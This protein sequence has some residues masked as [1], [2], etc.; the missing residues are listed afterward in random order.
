[1]AGDYYSHSNFPQ[2]N[3]RASSALMRAE[4]DKIEVG[5]DKLPNLPGNGAEI[6]TIKADATGLESK[7]PAELHL[8]RDDGDAYTGTHDFTGATVQLS[9]ATGATQLASD[10][11]TKLATTAFV[12][13][14]SF[15]AALPVQTVGDAGKFIQT[16]GTNASWVGVLPSQTGNNGK[17]LQTDGV[18]VSWQTAFPLGIANGGTLPS[19]QGTYTTAATFNMPDLTGSAGLMIFP[20]NSVATA[21]DGWTVTF[22][23][24]AKALVAGVTPH[25]SWG[26]NLAA[27]AP[28]LKASATITG[29][30]A[31][32]GV[33]QITASTVAIFYYAGSS[34][35]GVVIYDT[36]DDTMGTP[37]SLHAV[38]S[39]DYAP[40]IYATATG[41]VCSSAT[42]TNYYIN[43]CTV[44]GK[45]ITA[46]ASTVIAYTNKSGSDQ[47]PLQKLSDTSYLLV[48]NSGQ[49][50][51]ITVSGTT[52]TAG[53]DTNYVTGLSG[54]YYGQLGVKV[55]NS[56]TVLVA[57]A[58]GA[59]APFTLN[60]RCITVSGTT[61][62]PQANATG[63]VT[64]SSLSYA[65]GLRDYAAGG[66]FLCAYRRSDNS[67]LDAVGIS[68]SGVNA[69]IGAAVAL[70]TSSATIGYVATNYLAARSESILPYSSSV[71]LCATTAGSTLVAVSISGTTLTVGGNYITSGT[72][73]LHKDVSTDS[74]FLVFSHGGTQADIITVSGTTIIQA[75]ATNPWGY[76]SNDVVCFAT[77]TFAGVSVKVAG[78]WYGDYTYPLV[79]ISATRGAYTTTNTLLIRG[80]LE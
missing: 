5:C 10:N 6:V 68:V 35:A 24:A 20:T 17:V 36:S 69:T 46:V 27:L 64:L 55:V 60:A 41:F 8:A 65:G 77:P 63:A 52:V 80:P 29:I 74:A 43:A 42:T 25:G 40:C 50:N 34:G 22:G 51:A 53:A 73:Y 70:T 26:S 13:A 47:H 16:D 19:K 30:A 59:G 79:P 78:T 4:L 1:M 66:P 7:T 49:C 33:A 28:P 54:T 61:A 58:A 44:S 76:G 57:M 37:V 2:T 18:D 72:P 38:S 31:V 14:V 23:T 48:D 62:T 67:Y 9:A 71:M 32:M 45:V 3:T 11:S 56:T 12:N 39:S 15:N 21:S 75:E